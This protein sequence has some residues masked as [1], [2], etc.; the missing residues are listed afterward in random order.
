MRIFNIVLTVFLFITAFPVCSQ[1]Y[2]HG[3][4]HYPP[5]LIHDDTAQ[6]N[7]AAKGWSNEIS[8]EVYRRLNYE[9]EFK[10]L[11][12]PR[13]IAGLKDGSVNFGNYANENNISEPEIYADD[14]LYPI[15]IDMYVISHKGMA[16]P[17]SIEDF[18]GKIVV[19][20]RG[21]IVGSYQALHKMETVK[22]HQPNQ[23]QSG[24]QAKKTVS[25]R[26]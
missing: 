25:V 16:I 23:I 19:S 7:D 17:K 11:P 1:K 26:V 15:S 18:K 13:M 20:K 14:T 8:K 24:I 4:I 22:V 21:R 9:V 6:G 12:W 10:L 5:N 2:I 3:Y